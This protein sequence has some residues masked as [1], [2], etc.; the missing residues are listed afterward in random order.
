MAMSSYA[1]LIRNDSY[2]LIIERRFAVSYVYFW[3]PHNFP[4]SAEYLAMKF[5]LTWRRVS[6]NLHLKQLIMT[7]NEKESPKQL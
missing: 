6:W 3:T 1:N 7:L 4:N 2:F 5:M